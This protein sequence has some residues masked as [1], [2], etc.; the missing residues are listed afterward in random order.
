MKSTVRLRSLAV[1]IPLIGLLAS[2]AA[3]TATTATTAATAAVTRAPFRGISN[4]T[5]SNWSGYAAH[6]VADSFTS[7]SA[8]WVQPAGKCTRRSTYSAFWVGLDGYTSSTVEQTGSE[9]DCIGGSPQYYAW[10]EMYPANSDNFTNTVS[11][12][13]HFTSSVTATGHVFTL[14]ITDATRGWSHTI[15]RSLPS[16]KESSAEVIAEAPCCTDAGDILPL[17]DF[18]TVQFSHSEANGSAIGKSKPTV[19]SMSPMSQGTSTD[20]TSKLSDGEAFSVAW[21]SN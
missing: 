10:F 17:T 1:M 19:I 7:V 11:P 13:D 18:G 15:V 8:S 5:S 20:H 14:K 3:T 21:V 6:G 12:G 9:V 2:A 4:S 16:A